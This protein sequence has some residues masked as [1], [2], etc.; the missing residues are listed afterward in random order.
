MLSTAEGA[1]STDCKGTNFRETLV[2][3]SF[4]RCNLTV[5]SWTCI[6]TA[7]W[8]YP[9]MSTVCWFCWC[10]DSSFAFLHHLCRM[11]IMPFRWELFLA[12]VEN[13]GMNWSGMG[14]TS[15]SKINSILFSHGGRMGYKW[16]TKSSMSPE[17]HLKR[18][19]TSWRRSFSLD[20]AKIRGSFNGE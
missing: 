15:P 2:D 19:S 7:R 14:R 9:C 3:K 20:K 11:N 10:I 5:D 16:W 1:L 6:S 12:V 17:V 8:L 4:N 13:G 18:C